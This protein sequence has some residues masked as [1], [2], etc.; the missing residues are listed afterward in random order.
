MSIKV[1][2]LEEAARELVHWLEINGDTWRY[3]EEVD[4][5]KK[6]LPPRKR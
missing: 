3:Q 6:H 1:D 5:I 2:K 4:E